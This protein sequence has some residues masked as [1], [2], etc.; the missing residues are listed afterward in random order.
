MSSHSP[1]ATCDRSRRTHSFDAS[2]AAS[3]WLFSS[4]KASCDSGVSAL[5]LRVLPPFSAATACD[6]AAEAPCCCGWKLLLLAVSS[7]LGGGLHT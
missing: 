4:C 1:F 6:S 3:D 7:F 2:A 5:L